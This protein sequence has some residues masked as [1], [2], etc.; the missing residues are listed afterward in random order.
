MHYPDQL[1]VTMLLTAG[2]S[3]PMVQERN[4][5]RSSVGSSSLLQV[6]SLAT[7]RLACMEPET[8]HS[9]NTPTAHTGQ[10]VRERGLVTYLE[11]VVVVV[12]EEQ[13]E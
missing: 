12:S 6:L 8:Q 13:V 4:W 10:V 1:W 7:I 2:L 3:C 11:I 9:L 5:L